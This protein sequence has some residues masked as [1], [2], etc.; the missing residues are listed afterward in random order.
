VLGASVY[1]FD[2]LSKTTAG[3]S[4]PHCAFIFVAGIAPDC[5]TGAVV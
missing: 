2:D 4:A 1:V 3:S 5:V